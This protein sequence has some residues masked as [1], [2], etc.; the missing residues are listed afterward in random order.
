LFNPFK[1]VLLL[2]I[3]IIIIAGGIAALV[4][5]EGS[6]VAL[7]VTTLSALYVFQ[8][9][10]LCS[11]DHT[12]NP[13]PEKCKMSSPSS[14]LFLLGSILILSIYT[15]KVALPIGVSA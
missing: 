4:N 10:L 11:P 15:S 9:L 1:F 7:Q 14:T 6:V 5:P 8:N 13:Y 12:I 2:I 3:I